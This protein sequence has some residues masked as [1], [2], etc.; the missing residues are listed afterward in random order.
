MYNKLNTKCDQNTSYNKRIFIINRYPPHTSIYRYTIDLLSVFGEKANL[1]NLHFN[2]K[3]GHFIEGG[4]NFFGRFRLFPSLNHFLR[5]AAFVN[6]K[7]YIENDTKY[8]RG[9]I[10]HYTNQ[11]SGSFHIPNVVEIVSIHDSPFYFETMSFFKKCYIKFLYE[12]L[13]KKPYIVTNTESLK[14]ELMRFGFTG[15][16]ATIY[17]PYSPIFHRLP[18]NKEDLRTKLGL[19]LDKKLIL[20][21]STDLQRKNLPV[22]KKVVEEL[23]NDFKLIRVGPSLGNSLTFKGIDDSTLN[24]L[25]NACDV[26]LFPS[27]YEG[28]GIPIVEAFAT[29]PPVVTSD[30]PT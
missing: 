19:P 4:E 17:L 16:I 25:Y 2:P 12:S 26:L 6:L 24:E 28:F 29:G 20:S 9:A 13:K 23:G 3:E 15:K 18:L 21:V 22:V 8:K 1:V 7:K 27:L 10:L 14:N 30:I 11:F 5:R